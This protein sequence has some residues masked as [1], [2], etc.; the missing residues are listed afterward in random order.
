MRPSPNGPGA[1]ESPAL[2]KIYR[3]RLPDRPGDPCEG[4]DT[5]QSL[6][7]EFSLSAHSVTVSPLGYSHAETA[8]AGD[9]EPG[10]A[11][12]TRLGVD[13]RLAAAVQAGHN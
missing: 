2:A 7:F 4:F 5:G 12:L 13:P 8:C 1:C 10:I 9:I 11:D 6:S 3:D